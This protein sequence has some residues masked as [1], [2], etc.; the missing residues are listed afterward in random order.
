VSIFESGVRGDRRVDV[1]AVANVA[2]AERV[3][4]PMDRIGRAHVAR[5]S[6]YGRGAFGE[7]VLATSRLIFPILLLVTAAAAAL[8]YGD[9]PARWL[10][11]LDVAGKPFDTGLLSLP[12]TLFVVQL[13]NRRYGAGYAFLQLLGAAALGVA[14]AIYANQDLVLL[15]GTE[16]PPMRM[17]A[18][19]GAGLVVAQ[20]FSIVVFDRLR[21][22][23]W[24]QAPLFASLFGG[25]ALAAVAYPIAY[26]GAGV[27][28]FQPMLS[29][30]GINI[31]TALL[32]LVPY[33]LLRAVIAPLPG[34]G[35]Y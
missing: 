21:G 20:L 31:V 12:L 7:A 10:G 22:P 19:F 35:G 3:R 16:L 17:I 13:T 28:W 33:W 26:L 29:Y 4:R 8:I 30:I 23:R 34:F 27:D 32:L 18:A 1:R 6:D 9:A 11:E 5:S 25:I 2:D 24:W 15:R 14:A